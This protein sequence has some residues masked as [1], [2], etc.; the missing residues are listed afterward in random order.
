MRSI[1]PIEGVRTAKSVVAACPEGSVG[2]S[3]CV[4]IQL[5]VPTQCDRAGV[6]PV[7]PK[8]LDATGRPLSVRIGYDMCFEVP[9]STPIAIVLMLFSHPEV[10][11]RL[12][13][14]ER[15]I[16]EPEWLTNETFIDPFGN[17][18]AR[19]VVPAGG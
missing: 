7:E 10:T 1:Q 4:A 12:E 8:Y 5:P 13:S 19:V 6:A 2:M 14:P 9:G 15:M 16:I 11:P 17:K 3:Q 18:C